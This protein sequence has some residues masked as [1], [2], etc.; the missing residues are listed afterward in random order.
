[1]L[2]RREVLTARVPGLREWLNEP[3]PALIEAVAEGV[4][5]HVDTLRSRGIEFYGY[6]LLPRAPYDI[7][8]LVAVT[9]TRPDIKVPATDERYRYYRCSV[10]EWAHWDHGGFEAANALLAEA[11]ARFRSLHSKAGGEDTLDKFEIAHGN[12]LLGAVVDGL[13]SAKAG[14]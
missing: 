13:Q 7:H 12:A 11:N 2:G 8:R 1:K 3:S 10:D 5:A 6:A 4:A 9:H 14:G